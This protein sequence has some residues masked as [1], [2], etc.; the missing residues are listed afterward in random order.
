MVGIGS[1]LVKGIPNAYTHPDFI[2]FYPFG[3]S[4]VW[5]NNTQRDLQLKHFLI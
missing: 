2:G 5:Q 3:E 1:K 4:Y